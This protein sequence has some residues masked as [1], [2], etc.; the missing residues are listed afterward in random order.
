M[1]PTGISIQEMGDAASMT[2]KKTFSYL[3]KLF[4]DTYFG[5][6]SQC[7]QEMENIKG[8]LYTRA[9]IIYCIAILLKTFKIVM[10]SDDWQL[11]YKEK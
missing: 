6:D 5:G 8:I 11:A 7:K 1:V 4:M 10:G 3:R 2:S 9:W